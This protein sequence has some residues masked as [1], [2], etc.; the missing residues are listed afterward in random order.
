LT[1]LEG[2]GNFI[3]HRLSPFIYRIHAADR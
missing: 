2:L 1:P 3:E